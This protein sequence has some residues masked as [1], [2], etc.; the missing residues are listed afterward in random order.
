MKL[1]TKLVTGFGAVIV[2]MLVLGATGY[3]MFTKVKSNVGDLSG[4][5][6]AALQRASDIER[7]A[8]ESLQQEKSYLL[9]RDQNSQSQGRD[10]LK[11]LLSQ[12]NDIDKLAES[13][14]DA[15]LASKSAEV[16]KAT[17]EY[18]KLFEQ[19]VAAVERN[20]LAEQRLDEKGA[21]VDAEADAFMTAKKNEYLEAKN[22]LAIVNNINAWTL[23]M[24]VSEKSYLL[25]QK[26]LHQQ[27][28]ERNINNLLKAFDALDKLH[29]NSTE[30]K[31]IG[32]AR[33]AT[34]EYQKAVKEWA[35][36]YQ[37][38]RE[39]GTLSELVKTM[40]RSGDTV[41]QAVDDYMIPK[42]GAVDRI[43]DSVFV[44]RE[45]G[46][47]ALNARL[48]EKSYII[49]RK[50]EQ[51][52]G[53]K[54]KV[55]EL[56]KFYEALRKLVIT[57]EDQ[58]RIERAAKA[59]EEYL[60]AAQSWVT[61]DHELRQQILPQMKQN[62]E[63]VIATARSAQSEA[64]QRSEQVGDQT[65][66]M[67]T[68]SN[69]V[70]VAALLAGVCIGALLA[71]G[72]T[73]SI[74]RPINRVIDG[75]DSGAS[76]VSGAAN[77]IQLASQRLA[78]GT[79][80]QAAAIEETSA[81]LEQ[82]ASM[83]RRNAEHAG[84]ANH[85]MAE[86]EDIVGKANQSM[87]QLT[88]SMADISKASEETRKIIKT[89]DEIAFQTNLLA[90]NAAVE[91][92][93]AG[94]AGAGFAVVADEVRNLAMRA[95]DAAKNTAALIDGTVKSV[96]SGA[97]LVDKTNSEFS[98]VTE[99]ARK[100]SNLIS[101][102]AAASNEQTQ[103]IDQVCKAI[104][105]MDSVVQRNAASA[106]ESAAA[107]EEMNAQA[108]QMKTFVG[109][110]VALVGVHQALAQDRPAG[111]SAAL[112]TEPSYLKTTKIITQVDRRGSS[113]LRKALPAGGS[114]TKH[115]EGETDGASDG[116]SF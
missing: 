82:M 29:P 19:A 76:E 114:G 47:T 116:D 58:Q 90:L 80:E 89:I 98:Q 110:L 93:R 45:M 51:W 36:E 65:Q 95:A 64:A 84:Q 56:S 22:A 8:F 4:H 41:S 62:G 12:L 11:Q 48:D 40:N 16:R 15:A 60:A 79:S 78:D 75:L 44:V 23:E 73:R 59:T 52:E 81:S 107:S 99:R 111:E 24:R 102:V 50:S 103:G 113:A 5:N 108:E 18:G 67:A 53:L 32:L 106:E 66:A 21:I 27:A 72:I 88:S 35:A 94:E 7:T 91:A 86:V 42:Q 100:M 25:D 104:A 83:T 38:D 39:S 101:E 10:K 109:D 57:P 13:Y 46:E 71:W 31:L 68:T 63:K 97:G 112:L 20:R 30:V 105:E 54:Q 115:G 34:L 2:I 9:D 49:N 14:Q 92:A 43:A 70:I 74:T 85:L 55:Q 6:L 1:R 77:Q 3:F 17:E 28:I 26:Q 33:K 87:E 61:D 96:L 37:R 69:R